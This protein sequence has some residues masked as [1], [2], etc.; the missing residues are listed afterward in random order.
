MPKFSEKSLE[1]LRTCDPRLQALFAQVIQIVDCVIL[2][3]HR[4][5]EA[6]NRAVRE[7]KSQL[8]Y[9]RGKHNHVPSRAVDAAPYPIDWA[10][11]ARFYHF[12]GIV[13]G[14]AAQMKIP[15]RYGGDWDG[16]FNVTEE[17]FRDLVHFEVVG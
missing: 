17:R 10:D 9:P 4:G 14:V 16:D 8:P 2:E 1:R 11:S 7:G 6:Q 3:G 15:I 5:E 13:R 12:A